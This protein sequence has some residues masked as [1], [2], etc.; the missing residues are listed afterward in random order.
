MEL[1][2]G[3]RA[4]D[5]ETDRLRVHVL[6]AGPPDGVPVV[7]V[8]GN[9]ST[10]RFYERFLADAADGPYRF[11][12]PDMRGFGRTERVPLDATRGLRDWSDECT[13]S[14]APSGS[15]PRSTSPAGRPGAPPS[16]ATPS[17]G[18]SPP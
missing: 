8:H 5:V 14:C 11:L 9:L 7:L 6:E 16:P 15:T 13:R 1:L 2:P 10:G 18:R 17:T 4:H 12:A 3:V